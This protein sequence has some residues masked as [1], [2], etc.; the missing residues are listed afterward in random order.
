V[1]EEAAVTATARDRMV[2][3]AAQ[4][5]RRHGYHAVG[6]RRIVEE[7]GAPRGSIYHHFP[8]GKEQL[9]TEAVQFAGRALVREVDRAAGDAGDLASAMVALG[10]LL[11]DALEASDF[12]DGCPVATVALETTAEVPA[13]ATACRAVLRDWVR[14]L[15]DHLGA[16][17]WEPDDA[18]AFATTIVAAFEGALLLARVE[19]DV[20]PL[21][22]VAAQLAAQVP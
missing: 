18:T 4:L 5:F 8:G 13:V 21:R 3:T 2:R 10:D 6:F 19:R 9:A 22:T 12:A 15:A 17:G 14:V 16:E 11:A 1:S 20:A 7:A